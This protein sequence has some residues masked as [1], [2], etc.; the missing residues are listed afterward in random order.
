[1]VMSKHIYLDLVYGHETPF[2]S[3]CS[4]LPFEKFA[5]HFDEIIQLFRLDNTQIDTIALT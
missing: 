1:M 5:T 4:Q 2:R 3:A